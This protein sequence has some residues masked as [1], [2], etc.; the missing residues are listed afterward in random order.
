VLRGSARK[1]LPRNAC[2]HQ[3]SLIAETLFEAM[4]LGPTLWFRALDLI[5]AAKTGLSA[6]ALEHDLGINDPP[7]WL[8]H[9]TLM[10]TSRTTTLNHSGLSHTARALATPGFVHRLAGH[11][12][13]FT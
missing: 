1:S 11:G 3:T 4:K 6:L 7:A 8:I 12:R 5:G 13:R 10:Q 9:H 2:H